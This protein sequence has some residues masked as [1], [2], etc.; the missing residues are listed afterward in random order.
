MEQARERE[1]ETDKKAT[2]SENGTKGLSLGW[3]DYWSNKIL[4][5]KN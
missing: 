5:N 3:T 4:D 1:R 2:K